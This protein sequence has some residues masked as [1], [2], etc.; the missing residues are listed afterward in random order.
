M[1]E[2]SF[3]KLLQMPPHKDISRVNRL[4]IESSFT[5][6]TDELVRIINRL[7]Y[8]FAAEQAREHNILLKSQLE[9]AS[10]KFGDDFDLDYFCDVG[11]SDLFNDFMELHGSED[12]YTKA[13]DFNPDYNI[14]GELASLK[15]KALVAVRHQR[16]SKTHECIDYVEGAF[17]KALK[18]IG[19]N[20]N[21]EISGVSKSLILTMSVMNDIGGMQF[22]LPKAVELHKTI[23]DVD[24]YIDYFS[25]S[26]RE[27]SLKYGVSFKTISTVVKR[28]RAAI[29]EYEDGV[30]ENN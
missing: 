11:G 2:K 21:D 29:K 12:F 20:P 16:F 14:N 24:M 6:T 23:S 26:L 30:N 25:M 4:V 27:A 17:Q 18:K 1:S 7:G 10:E 9:S 8:A 5:L 19:V 15:R 22:Y 28:V 13:L 3:R